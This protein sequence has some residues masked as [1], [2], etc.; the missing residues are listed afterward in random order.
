VEREVS[1]YAVF[2][3]EISTIT[4]F[5]TLSSLAWAIGSALLSFA[6]GIWTNAQFV[7]KMSPEGTV[8]AHVVAPGLCALTL[9]AYGL[10]LWAISARGKTWRAV[11]AQS[12]PS[13]P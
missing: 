4:V 1:A 8:L 10:G 3:N 7:E 11:R 2:E 12:K 6:I 5:N 13:Q 9:V